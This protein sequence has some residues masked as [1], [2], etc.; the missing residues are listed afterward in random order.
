MILNPL[1][2]DLILDELLAI[3]NL[4]KI[5][6]FV[7]Y[8]NQHVNPKHATLGEFTGPEIKI[9][10]T[11]ICKMLDLGINIT[12][13]K[14]DKK[15]LISDIYFKDNLYFIYT[16]LHEVEHAID[17]YNLVDNKNDLRTML[18]ALEFFYKQNVGFNNNMSYLYSY[19]FGERETILSNI[20]YRLHFKKE[21]KFYFSNYN[22]SFMERVANIEAYKK[23]LSLI[24]PIKDDIRGVYQFQK[25][26]LFDTRM[27]SYDTH[28][29]SP[30]TN[31]FKNLGY[32]HEF[33]S[34]IPDDIDLET[35][36]DYGLKLTKKDL[37]L[38][39]KH[40]DDLF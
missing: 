10:Y 14:S 35:R 16:L 36:I 25:D 26:I 15:L 40:Y 2:I 27:M 7:Y 19:Y 33:N 4:D 12:D 30:T 29:T 5:N 34:L 1:T 31:F 8:K 38:S 20:I 3:N 37:E 13:F 11:T 39:S 6:T 23:V 24:E 9:N 28:E 21:R 18:F 32:S 22:I 17:Y